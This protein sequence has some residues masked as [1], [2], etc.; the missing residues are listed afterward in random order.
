VLNAVDGTSV[1][2]DGSQLLE[3]RGELTVLAD[4]VQDAAERHGSVVLVAGEPGIGKST[5][6]RA[7]LGDPALAAR[8]LVGWCDD[9][10]TSRTYGPFRDVARTTGGALAE[11][12]ASSD[13]PGVMEALHELLNDPLR[14]TALVMEDVHWA[15]E[16]TLDVVRF[17]GRRIVRLPAVLVLTYRPDELEADHPLHRVLGGFPSGAVRRVQPRPLSTGAIAELLAGT[18]LDAE[19][20]L[21]LTGGNPFYVTELARHPGERLPASVSD[22]VVGRLHRLPSRSQQAV[23]LVAIHPRALPLQQAIG[24]LGTITELAVAESHG[25][26][27]LAE[28]VVGFRHELLRQAVLGSLPAATRIAHHET[29]LEY[30]LSESDRGSSRG[31]ASAAILHHAVEA[32]RGDV[33]ARVG[34]AVAHAAFDAGAHL[35]AVAHQD[36]VLRYEELVDPGD[37]ARLFVERSWSLYNLHHF[38]EAVTAAERSIAAYE[39]LGDRQM[40][41]RMTLTRCRMLYIANRVGEAFTALAEA[42]AL[43]PGCEPYVRAEYLANRSALLHLTDRYEEVLDGAEAALAAARA[44]DRADLLAHVENYAGCAAAMLGDFDTGIE[45]VRRAKRIAEDGGWIEATARAHTNLVELLVQARRWDE[46]DAAIVEA[47][48][49]Y[50][51]H[52]F[53]AHRYNTLGQR[54]FVA[55]LRG[56]WSAAEQILADVAVPVRGAG[57]LGAIWATARAMLAVRSGAEGAEDALAAAWEPALTSRSSQYIVPVAIAA[58]ERAWTLDQPEEADPFVAPALEVSRGWWRELLLWRLDLV[59]E[60]RPDGVVRLEPEGTSLAGDWRAAAARWRELRLPFELGIELLRSG[61]EDAMREA[62]A[63]FDGLGAEPAARL[64][65]RRLR[66]AGVQH[67]PRRPRASTRNHPAGLTERQAEV[68]ALLSEGLTNAQIAA[69]LVVS[70]RTVDHHVAAVLQKLRVGTRQEAAALA[71]GSGAAPSPLA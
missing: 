39:A 15:D 35:Q 2:P 57:V 59:R 51:R 18:D 8:P 16:A 66:E 63:V 5:L 9:L 3:R 48:R 13:T 44:V 28:G 21:A 41:C 47:L 43:L 30:L 29:T 58:I 46:A 25:L 10:L 34:P 33:V 38:E 27:T 54:A 42:E 24:L 71:T 22:A 50:E 62:L 12:I 14:P 67:L 68:L 40:R 17:L 37:L 4:A 23:G 55:I 52:D 26:V 64:A 19:E 32:G 7:W 49:Y 65:R 61:D 6:V 31:D 53:Q 60:H 20:V 69:Q 36:H 11:A 45:Q 1:G 56:D 70:V